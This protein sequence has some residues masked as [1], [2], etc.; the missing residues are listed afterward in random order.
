MLN[1]C[2]FI[3]KGVSNFT[4]L[5]SWIKPMTP[6]FI[7]IKILFSSSYANIKYHLSD[8]EKKSRLFRWF[9]R[10]IADGWGGAAH[11]PPDG[12]VHLFRSRGSWIKQRSTRKMAL[13]TATG[14]ERE[15]NVNG[16]Y[17]LDTRWRNIASTLPDFTCQVCFNVIIKAWSRFWGRQ[18]YEITWFMTV[19]HMIQMLYIHQI[20]FWWWFRIP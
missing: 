16:D 2:W 13:K 17:S 9:F 1:R 18:D 19:S 10:F 20:M 6:C 5:L 4:C 15:S 12:P 8:P 3:I 7:R 14:K 11:R